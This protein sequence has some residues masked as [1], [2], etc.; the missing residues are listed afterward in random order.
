MLDIFTYLTFLALI[1]HFFTFS[2]SLSLKAVVK[3]AAKK[4]DFPF[5]GGLFFY[6]H[7]ESFF[8]IFFYS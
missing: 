4:E 8:I 5:N 3:A 1:F 2:S 6:S 7:N